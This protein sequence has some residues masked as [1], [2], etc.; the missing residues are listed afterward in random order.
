MEY[1]V[2]KLCCVKFLLLYN[3]LFCIILLYFLQFEKKKFAFPRS[4]IVIN[5]CIVLKRDHASM[6]RI[7]YRNGYPCRL[8]MASWACVRWWSDDTVRAAPWHPRVPFLVWS[9]LHTIKASPAVFFCRVALNLARFF[10]STE[11]TENSQE[12]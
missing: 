7:I 2:Y 1:I 8:W 5:T 6:K 4:R 11:K 9:P 10:N 12:A 3:R